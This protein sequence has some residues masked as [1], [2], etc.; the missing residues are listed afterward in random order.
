MIDDQGNTNCA[1]IASWANNYYMTDASFFARFSDS[2]IKM[3]DF[4]AQGMPKIV[5]MGGANHDV[6]YSSE[7]SVD[8]SALQKAIADQ[9]ALT[10]DVRSSATT[11][12]NIFPNPSAD[13]VHVSLDTKS[14]QSVCVELL[15]ANGQIVCDY[16]STDLNITNNSFT[17]N[18]TD[19]VS[20]SYFL[21]TTSA[22]GSSVTKLVVAH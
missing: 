16:S 15:N 5:V 8:A 18:T 10:S 12:L 9:I 17:I 22:A 7:N 1:S 6:L 3:T 13:F 4:G 19:L 20:G 2:K 14:T 11:S 21:R